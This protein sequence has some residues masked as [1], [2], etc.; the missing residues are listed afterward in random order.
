MQTTGHIQIKPTSTMFA[1][2]AAR[3]KYYNLTTNSI[4]RHLLA[5]ALNNLDWRYYP[6]VRL[7]AN[8][9]DNFDTFEQCADHIG[10][11]LEG[12]LS[13]LEKIDENKRAKMIF[14]EGVRYIRSRNDNLTLN[15][16]EGNFSPSVTKFY[17]QLSKP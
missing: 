6:L 7:M 8:A 17:K 16:D 12:A 11:F 14:D 5:L 4:C 2:L 3:S 13:N 10:A 9:N 1:N 15:F